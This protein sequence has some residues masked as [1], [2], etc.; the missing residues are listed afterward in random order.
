MSNKLADALGT[1]HHLTM[2]HVALLPGHGKSLVRPASA[3]QGIG[4]SVLV[5]EI[6]LLI[7]SAVIR[8]SP[9]GFQG[10]ISYHAGANWKP[11]PRTRTTQSDS[12]QV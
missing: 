5:R 4:S 8:C 12:I 6:V 11:V 2:M 3:Q 7:L 9:T 1:S 10:V